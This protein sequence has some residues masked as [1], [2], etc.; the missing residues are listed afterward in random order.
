MDYNSRVVQCL[1]QPDAA[2]DGAAVEAVAAEAG[3]LPSFVV[4]SRP[5]LLTVACT[6]ADA[7]ERPHPDPQGSLNGKHVA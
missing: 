4:E 6:S 3:L 5:S 7:P 1:R 2:T